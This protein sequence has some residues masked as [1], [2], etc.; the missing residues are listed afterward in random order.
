MTTRRLLGLLFTLLA[1]LGATTPVVA[2]PNTA[3][4][5]ADDIKYYQ[6]PWGDSPYAKY[7]QLYRKNHY[8]EVTNGRNVAV[9]LFEKDGVQMAVAV[10]SFSRL[11]PPAKPQIDFDV[12]QD[13]AMLRTET[14]DS[15]GYGGDAHESLGLP[16]GDARKFHSEPLLAS[17]TLLR[18][19]NDLVTVG[20]SERQFCVTPGIQCWYEIRGGG[21]KPPLF[22]KLH[23]FYYNWKIHNAAE[24][25]DG[26]AG[27]EAT[28]EQD[29]ALARE[30]TKKINK[31][32]NAWRADGAKIGPLP[33]SDLSAVISDATAAE[34]NEGS[35]VDTLN[36][37]APPPGDTGGIDL[38][39]VELRY[40]ADPGPDKGMRY[41]V[42]GTTAPETINRE[43]GQ[44]NLTQASDAF[45][46]WLSLS[47][48]KFWV[49]LN[50]AEPDRIIDPALAATDAGRI[51][52]RA[53]L[54]LK[55]SVGRFI[56]PDTALGAE[57]WKSLRAGPGQQVCLSF[58]QWIVPAPATVHSDDDSIHILDAPLEVKLESEYRRDHGQGDPACESTGQDV[59][60]YNERVYRRLILPQV[61]KAVDSAPE[62]ADLRRV[63]LSRVA[64]AWYRELSSRRV[65]TYAGYINRGDALAWPAREPWSPRRVF[66]DYVASYTNGEFNVSQQEE[67]GNYILTHTYVYGGVD[68]SQ[69]PYNEVD[70]AAFR[71]HWPDVAAA[72]A[73]S[74]DRRTLE[75]PSH[76]W[77]GVRGTPQA[78][79]VLAALPEEPALGKWAWLGIVVGG[80]LVLLLLSGVVAVVL[81]TLRKGP[82]PVWVDRA[83]ARGGTT[84]DA[85]VKGDRVRVDV[86]AGSSDRDPVPGPTGHEEQAFHVRIRRVSL[87]AKALVVIVAV[88]G[89]VVGFVIWPNPADRPSALVTLA[90]EQAP[91]PVSVAP[92][93]R[94]PHRITSTLRPPPT[95]GTCFGGEITG[96]VA[97]G[98]AKVDCGSP[99]AHYRS[100]DFFP[101]T[102]DM[103][104]CDTV[105]ETQYTYSVTW[106]RGGVPTSKTVYCLIGLGSYAR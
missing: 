101:G 31:T 45:F 97:F 34:P 80:L 60:D 40:L 57:F 89:A 27:P 69:V 36:G 35:L 74:A 68:F 79:E 61:Q 5:P 10:A 6:K 71:E 86:P 102:S 75:G 12:F 17:W 23:A 32:I 77:L 24:V 91:P 14:F 2:Q 48:D 82:V 37:R 78:Q 54:E 56:H 53:D 98:V 21:S 26:S 64:A 42:R 94:P 46:V 96:N 106:L 33:E 22:P 11:T 63:H 30:T 19:V 92:P 62:Y 58:R 7:I 28:V 3:N 66:D 41:S 18:G 8:P 51:M 38:S 99:D 13:G 65:T 81:Q 104:R 49:N 88:V 90:R 70:D 67:A 50:P 4:V 72:V 9:V 16:K 85:Y 76:A 59:L 15:D 93:E 44:A 73:G 43:A 103:S 84:T 55:K 83:E 105:P 29:N 100:I 47:T 87:G 52:L 95:E 39:T 20:E 25:E 1:L